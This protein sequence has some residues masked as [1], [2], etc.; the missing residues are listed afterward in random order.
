VEVIGFIIIGAIFGVAVLA[1]ALHE[2]YAAGWNACVYD[3][4]TRDPMDPT[5]TVYR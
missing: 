5:R 3:A 4:A 2:A 1:L